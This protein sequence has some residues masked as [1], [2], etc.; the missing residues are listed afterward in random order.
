MQWVCSAA[1]SA[2]G[3]CIPLPQPCDRRC[4]PTHSL[5]EPT[6]VCHPLTL[7]TT[8]DNSSSTCLVDQALVEMRD[9]S[10]MCADA[11]KLP[12]FTGRTCTKDGTVYCNQRDRCINT[13]V[14]NPCVPCLPPFSECPLSGVC[15]VDMSRCCPS[16]LL[17]YCNYTASCQNS[18][19]P[20]VPPP[21]VIPNAT[22]NTAPQLL[23]ELVFAGSVD[24]QTALASQTSPDTGCVA[25]YTADWALSTR[26]WPVCVGL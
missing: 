3:T 21:T 10:R 7:S 11:S 9:G 12:S 25:G 13:A 18:S 22:L 19:M 8:C 2:N 4:D 1:N 24:Q 5:C 6:N 15:E 14:A 17:V 20:C 23:T 26:K 16:S